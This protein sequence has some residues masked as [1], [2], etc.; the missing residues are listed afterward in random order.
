MA[1]I[2]QIELS[3]RDFD[4]LKDA[5]EIL[6]FPSLPAKITNIIGVPI[7][8]AL[9]RIPDNWSTSI[10]S[11]ARKALTRA[12]DV[13]VDQMDTG[14]IGKPASIG[15]H[16]FI[17]GISGAAGGAFGLPALALELPISTVIMLRAIADVARSEGENLED[18]ESRLACLEVFALGGRSEG[19]N[20][21]ETGYFGVRVALAKSVTEAVKYITAKGIADDSAPALVR[22]ISKIATRF[23]ATVS[24]KVAAQTIPIIGAASGAAIN[25]LFTGHFQDMAHGHFTIRRLERK[26][27]PDLIRSEYEKLKNYN[28]NP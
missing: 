28:F 15:W 8:S 6:E 23:G 16:K 21:S 3:P 9:E 18:I 24:E 17:S 12:L 5:Y 25:V 27:S 22:F 20:A 2:E 4:A 11:A 10:Y 19:D 13:V 26:Y 7:E 14:D 1:T